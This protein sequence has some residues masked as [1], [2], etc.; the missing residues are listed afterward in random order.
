M[1]TLPT[2]ALPQLYTRL[3]EQIKIRLAA[4]SSELRLASADRDTFEGI[5][6]AESACVQLRKTTELLAL[7][8]VVAHNEHELFRSKKFVSEW[9]AD[10]IFAA[11]NK[12][13]KESFPVR[14]T[15]DGVTNDGYANAIIE[16]EGFLT[17]EGLCKIY[18]D[19]GQLLHIG[20]LRAVITTTKII[21]LGEIQR[22]RKEIM[23]LLNNHIVFL[24]D[25]EKIMYVSIA[26]APDGA[27]ECLLQDVFEF[28]TVL[29]PPHR[30]RRYRTVP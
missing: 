8:V 27:V 25:R 13:N 24:P 19:C 26:K 1:V 28:E 21:D 5:V 9:N 16:D 4:V 17:R 20:K 6:R 18:H 3:M 11:L 23:Q 7:A 12:L 2:T 30:I 14:F 22:W 29:A 15:I 10:A